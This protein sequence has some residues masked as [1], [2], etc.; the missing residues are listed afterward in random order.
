MELFEL[1]AGNARVGFKDI[2]GSI[3][4][5]LACENQSTW[6]FMLSGDGDSGR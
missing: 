5:V 6:K 4:R 3:V 2:T 1:L